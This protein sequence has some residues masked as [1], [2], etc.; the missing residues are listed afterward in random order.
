MGDTRFT[1]GQ[2]RDVAENQAQAHSRAGITSAVQSERDSHSLGVPHVF[3][4]SPGGSPDLVKLRPESEQRPGSIVEQDGLISA[5]KEGAA[6]G[7]SLAHIGESSDSTLSWGRGGAVESS[8]GGY[9]DP[10]KLP[11]DIATAS[12]TAPQTIGSA[13]QPEPLGRPLEPVSSHG[14]AGNWSMQDLVANTQIGSADSRNFQP[15]T[16]VGRRPR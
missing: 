10:G 8:P 4:E 3:D 15:I 2:S 7:R 11:S 14:A 9:G 6:V 16:T 13:P 5:A 1:V 12:G